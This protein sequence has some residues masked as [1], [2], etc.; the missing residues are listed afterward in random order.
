MKAENSFSIPT[1][2]RD[3]FNDISQDKKH[4]MRGKSIKFYW[5]IWTIKV[6]LFHYFFLQCDIREER[7]R[8]ILKYFQLFT[9][10]TCYYGKNDKYMFSIPQALLL[11]LLQNSY[12]FFIPITRMKMCIFWL[13]NHY[14]QF[15]YKVLVSMCNNQEKPSIYAKLIQN[16][17]THI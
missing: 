2:H 6:A 12:E 4:S 17:A 7:W 16:W 8:N 15:C 14:W 5:N 3:P 11:I 10:H 9:E 13:C 1:R